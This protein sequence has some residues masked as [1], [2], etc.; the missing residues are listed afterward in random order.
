VK[1]FNLGMSFTVDEIGEH[2]DKI[3]CAIVFANMFFGVQP[4][5]ANE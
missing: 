3:S 2:L 1:F 4:A 5:N